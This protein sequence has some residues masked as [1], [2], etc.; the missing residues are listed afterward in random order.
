MR[1]YY[2]YHVKKALTVQNLVTIEVLDFPSDYASGEEEHGFYEFVYTDSGAITC[3][4]G[5]HVETLKQGELYFVPPHVPHHYRAASGKPVSVFILCFSSNSEILEVLHGKSTLNRAMRGLIGEVVTESKR[6]F[7]QPFDSKLELLESPAF[8]AQQLIENYLEQLLLLL[9]REKMQDN[10]D[11]HIVM[12]S[13]ELE[14]R[15]AGDIDNILRD[16]LYGTLT[17]D[18]VADATHYSKTYLNRV[19]RKFIGHSVMQ[20]YTILKIKEAKKLLRDGRSVSETSDLLCFDS[21]NYFTKVFRRITAL[22]PTEYQRKV[23]L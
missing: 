19:F 15:L 23:L 17:L 8:G 9:V 13:V 20:Y 11:I 10:A 14:D 21:P 16:N 18:T 22:T 7:R 12:N 4:A 1:K 6:A 2:T 5:E 3:Y